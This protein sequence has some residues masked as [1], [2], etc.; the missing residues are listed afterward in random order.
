M[1]PLAHMPIGNVVINM[2]ALI[3]AAKASINNDPSNQ[4]DDVIL[5][6]IK[7]RHSFLLVK[8]ILCVFV[9]LLRNSGLNI[10]IKDVKIDELD[11]YFLASIILIKT[12]V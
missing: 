12:S 7:A 3:E 2:Q 8:K 1:A 6:F 5:K 10:I 11:S 4:E 9:P